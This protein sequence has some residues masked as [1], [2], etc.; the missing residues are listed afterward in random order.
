MASTFT[1]RVTTP[2]GVQCDELVTSAT[3]P[4]PAGEIGVLPGHAPYVGLLG[5]GVVSY[6]PADGGETKRLVVS[7]GFATFGDDTLSL[8]ADG[9][10]LPGSIDPASLEAKKEELTKRL[11]SVSGYDGE[12]D[13]VRRELS[14]V[15][16]AEKL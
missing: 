11:Q 7:G 1:L 4:G 13:Y 10:D 16:A 5:V 8:T 9:A 6:T 2:H 14:R 3:L 12:W 15:E